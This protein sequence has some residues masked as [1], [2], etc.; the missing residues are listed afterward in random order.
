M[1]KVCGK[2]GSTKVSK[3]GTNMYSCSDCGHVFY[4]GNYSRRMNGVLILLIA[5]VSFLLGAV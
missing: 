3:C 4:D 1:I 5:A 2:C